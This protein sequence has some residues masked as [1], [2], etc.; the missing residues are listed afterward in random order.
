MKV[1]W[2]WIGAAPRIFVRVR[3]W[4]K[5]EW[6]IDQRIEA[7]AL[8]SGSR[9][10]QLTCPQLVCREGSDSSQH[11]KLLD[12]PTPW[13]QAGLNLTRSASTSSDQSLFQH[14]LAVVPN[15]REWWWHILV[16]VEPRWTR[17]WRTG[18]SSSGLVHSCPRMCPRLYLSVNGKWHGRFGFYPHGRDKE[19]RE[20]RKR[21]G[22]K[23]E[24]R[25]E[26]RRMKVFTHG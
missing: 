22:R 18:R 21:E 25:K 24:E 11:S 26:E 16:E 3:S 14:T 5:E 1:R 7:H 8:K 15:T 12:R 2:C 19:E 4:M 20:G 23:R 13:K 6:M 17:F 10:E 9:F